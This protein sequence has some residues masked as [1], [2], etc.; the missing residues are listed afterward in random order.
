M[1][2]G[3]GHL[4]LDGSAISS[5]ATTSVGGG[6]YVTG[7]TVTLQGGATITGNSAGID[8]GGI[9]VESGSL[10]GAVADGNVT[11]NVPNDISQ[12]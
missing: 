8:G 12:P 2:Y 3:N 6:I 11:G 4:I 5:N 9:Y 10:V 1:Y 7:G